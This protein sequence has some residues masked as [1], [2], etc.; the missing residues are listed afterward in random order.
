[1]AVATQRPDAMHFID[2]SLHSDDETIHHLLWHVTPTRGNTQGFW[3]IF[4]HQF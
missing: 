4:G 2:M 1:V 3:A